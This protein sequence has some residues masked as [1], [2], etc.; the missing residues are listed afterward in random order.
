VPRIDYY[1]TSLHRF[2]A[3]AVVLTS[4]GAVALRFPTGDRYASHAT[5]HGE[6]VALVEEVAPPAC[7]AALAAG[8]SSQFQ[9]RCEGVAYRVRVDPSTGAGQGDRWQVTLSAGEVA[10][11]AP[12]PGRVHARIE[13]SGS[14]AAAAPP[15]LA[16]IPVSAVS[17]DAPPLRL[18]SRPSIVPPA[19]PSKSASGAPPIDRL[20]RAMLELGASDLHLGAGAPPM[21]RVHGEI[22]FL[23]GQ[24]PLD[25]ESLERALVEIAP[26]KSRKEFAARRDTDFGYAIAGLARFRANLF[27]DRRGPGAVFR[28]IPTALLTPA[29][30]GLPPQVLELCDLARGLVVVTGPTGSGKSTTLATLVDHVNAH[31]SD[32][33]ITI[34]DPIE[35]VHENKRCLVTQRE[36]HSH[37]R[38]FKNALRA[39]LREDPDVV[40]VGEMRDLETIAIAVETA[41][42]GHLVFGT[43]HTTTAPSTVDRMIDQFAADRQEQIRQMLAESLRG[44]IAQTLCKRI[45]G[46]RIAAYEILLG[47]SAVANLIREKKTFQ[48]WSLMQT[49]R[50]Q[51]MLTLND[52][53]L[54]LVKRRLVEPGEAYQ[55]ATNKAELKGLLAREG[56]PLTPPAAAATAAA[57][58]G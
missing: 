41:E 20:L 42:T 11:P 12:P 56:I 30:L 44:V 52:S 37:T 33:I 47:S 28:A 4:G 48:L 8:S 51:G 36:V 27:V 10:P 31:R 25:A 7:R 34:E 9:H 57:A 29:Q 16:T 49:G 50:A 32:H 21:V 38:S 58:A 6:L 43:L 3:G 14:P 1:L 54:E 53:L 35:F 15:P 55:K 19:P 23:A 5:P 40:L 17:G 22:R 45:G 46:G 13:R 39:A 18:S 2:G 24:R 26:P